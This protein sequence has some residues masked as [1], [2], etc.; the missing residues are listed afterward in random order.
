MLER[1]PKVFWEEVKDIR[2]WDFEGD[3]VSLKA[4]ERVLLLERVE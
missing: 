3:G 2:R 4:E 1:V